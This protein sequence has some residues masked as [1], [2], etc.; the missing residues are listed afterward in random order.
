MQNKPASKSWHEI[1]VLLS[2][3]SIALTLG[4]WN[5]FASSS[6]NA[7]AAPT[8]ASPTDQPQPTNMVSITPT[9]SLSLLPGQVLLLGG[10]LP[11]TDRTSNQLHWYPYPAS[12]IMEEEV[13]SPRLPNPRLRPRIILIHDPKP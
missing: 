8:D 11:T 9:P 12:I 13:E 5:V 6:K 1:E 4:L 3:I 10:V 7:T 2:A